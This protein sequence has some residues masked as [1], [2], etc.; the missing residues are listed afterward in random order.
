M[1]GAISRGT[2]QIVFPVVDATGHLVGLVHSDDIAR[3]QSAPELELHV[4][5]ADL[6]G[7][8][9][10]VR[11]EDDL[12]TMFELM[13]A[14]GLSEVPVLDTEARVV[15]LIDEATIAQTFLRATESRS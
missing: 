15:G 4:I 6:M 2:R 9:V 14:E 10:S 5:A 1:L 12:L 13:R 8:P 3:L 7:P 11:S